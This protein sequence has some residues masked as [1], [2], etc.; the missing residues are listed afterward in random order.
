MKSVALNINSYESTIE[1][2]KVLIEGL[3]KGDVTNYKAKEKELK[4]AI[5]NAEWIT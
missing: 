3:D 2:L 4:L 5:K 1:Y